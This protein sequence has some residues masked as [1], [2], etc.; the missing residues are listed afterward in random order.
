MTDVTS[1]E[2][3][4]ELLVSAV[5]PDGDDQ[6]SGL[7]G[8]RFWRRFLRNRLAVGAGVF[9]LILLSLVLLAPL[10]TTHDP[11][12]A[13]NFADFL[14]NPSSEYW[15]G[16]DSVGRDIYT[17]VIYGT[18]YAF[19]AGGVAVFTALI[20]GVP[21]GLT[22]GF[23]R[24]WSDRII[25]RFV[26]A[27]VAVPAVVF[28]IAI[29]SV[30]GTGLVRA[31]FAI[32]IVYSMIITRLTRAEVFAAREELYVD[33]ARAAG[34]SNNRIMFRHILPNIAPA[35]IV[36]TTLLFATS[37]LA[38]AA[39]SFL[40]LGA[41][42]NQASWGRMLRS[43]Q[44]SIDQSIWPAFP[45][46]IAIFVTVVAFN[47]FGDGLRDAFGREARGGR[48]GV[49]DV[50]RAELPQGLAAEGA[51][52]AAS[53]PDSNALL[54][55]RDLSV[56]FPRPGTTD[57][58]D[59]VHGVDF[60]IGKGEIMALVGESGSGKSITALSVLGLVPDPG[61]ASASSIMLDGKELVDMD[62]NELREIRGKEIGLISQEPS[63]ALN[64]A[65]T[66]GRQIAEPLRYQLGMSKREARKR[67]I[68]LMIRVGIPDPEVRIDSYPHQFSGGMAQRVVIAMALACSPKLLIADE[69][70]TALDVTVQ[71]QVLDLIGDLSRELGVAVLLITH[72]LGVVSDLADKAAVMYAGE[73]V[74]SGRLIDVFHR[75]QHPYTEGLIKAIPRNEIREGD[76][77]TID[78]VV[79]PPWMW[80]KGCHFAPRCEYATDTCRAGSIELETSGASLVRCLRADELDLLG[81]AGNSVAVP[82]PIVE[83]GAH[84]G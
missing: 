36:Q 12:L 18:R 78:G 26:E 19:T 21:L 16:T 40:G 82:L 71:G 77:P 81:V 34:A 83:G 56:R 67:S 11:N 68:E 48:V 84:D 80:P 72:D 33:G 65:Y 10:I 25:M 29:I 15:W 4:D 62:F 59:V 75:P 58:V 24:G 7:G 44:E 47:V 17:R 49:G 70:T 51:G 41:S 46:G 79:P 64:P 63:A 30:V 27:V 22:I 2:R 8:S 38:E 76:L 69:P 50:E 61:K 52:G 43:A 20:I 35:L 53:R 3:V 42:T 6:A 74:E 1:T 13:T 45:P 54:S 55:V 23:F 73:I 31:M 66:V 14:K 28:A 9:L 32:G 39:L 57:D 37:V 5:E 60:D